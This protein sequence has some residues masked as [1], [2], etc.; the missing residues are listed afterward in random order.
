M[1]NSIERHSRANRAGLMI[2][3]SRIHRYLR[4]GKLANR[5]G[6]GAPVYL[7][8]ILEYLLAEIIDTAAV[9]TLQNNKRRITSRFLNLAI[10]NDNEMD[11]LLSQVHICKGGVLPNINQMLL[12][13]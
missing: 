6:S 9:V 5:I 1:E 11:K 3:V 7:A 10:R 4:N 12:P 13:K 8:A 2:P